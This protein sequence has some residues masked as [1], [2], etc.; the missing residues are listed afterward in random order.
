MDKT[1]ISVKQHGVGKCWAQFSKLWPPLGQ[2][3]MYLSF[4][5]AALQ[6]GEEAQGDLTAS[7]SLLFLGQAWYKA[8]NSA[9]HGQVAVCASLWWEGPVLD[10]AH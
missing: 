6:L 9:R 3:H 8:G 7:F 1:D 2:G 5:R 4:S 10:L